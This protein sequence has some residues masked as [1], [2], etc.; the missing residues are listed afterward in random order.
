LYLSRAFVNDRKQRVFA[1]DISE[2]M[3]MDAPSAADRPSLTI[4]A[5]EIT[6]NQGTDSVVLTERP[7]AS[8]PIKESPGYLTYLGKRYVHTQEL[9]TCTL[10]MENVKLN[11]EDWLQIQFSVK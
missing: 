3:L 7:P 8:T 10:Q 4:L 11:G 5:N 6:S 1:N 2:S 9:S